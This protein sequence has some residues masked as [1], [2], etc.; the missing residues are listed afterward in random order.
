MEFL[1]FTEQKYRATLDKWCT[2]AE[3]Y[4]AFPQ[5]VERRLQCVVDALGGAA[6]GRHQTMAYGVFL[7]GSDIAVCTCELVLSDRGQLAGKWLKMLSITM[8]PEVDFLLCQEDYSATQ[9][10]VQ[11]YK[12]AVLGSFAVRLDHDADTLKL[13]GRSDSQLKFLMALL[14]VLEESQDSGLSAKRE[15]RWLVLRTI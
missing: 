14:A 2:E 11:A 12:A 5:E 8:S 10:I 4:D 1:P 15:G 13:Y 3:H 9:T 7:P 6:K